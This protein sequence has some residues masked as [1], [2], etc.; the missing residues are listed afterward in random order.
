LSPS[1]ASPG[2]RPRFYDYL[3]PDF[4]NATAFTPTDA[5]LLAAWAKCTMAL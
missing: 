2:W 4:T 5:M 3:Y 1:I